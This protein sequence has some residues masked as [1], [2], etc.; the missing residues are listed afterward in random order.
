MTRDYLLNILL[1][2]GFF[3]ST[4]D[5]ER[6]GHILSGIVVYFRPENTYTIYAKN[7]HVYSAITSPEE[8]LDTVY[9]ELALAE[10]KRIYN[11]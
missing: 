8:V 4:S 11:E 10:H 9:K 5:H 2:L 6:C 7:E 3:R 1:L